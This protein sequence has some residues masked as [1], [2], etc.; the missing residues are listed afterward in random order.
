MK[1]YNE[2]RKQNATAIDAPV[3]GGD[4]GARNATLSIMLGGE[5]SD[6]DKLMPIF[7]ILGKNVKHMGP[8]GI[9][10]N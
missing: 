10:H 6:I 4:I 8:A 9:Y 5:K 3:S 1:I 2:A 7:N